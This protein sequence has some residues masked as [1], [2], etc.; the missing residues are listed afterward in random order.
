MMNGVGIT[1]II[2]NYVIIRLNW[3]FKSSLNI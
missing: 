3:V 1:N 2:C